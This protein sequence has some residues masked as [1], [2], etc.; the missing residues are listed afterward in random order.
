MLRSLVGSEMCIRDS[1]LNGGKGNDELYAQDGDD[2]L[3]G[4]PGANFFDCGSG[5]DTVVDFDPSKGD[6]TNDNCE[7][8]RTVL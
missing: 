5:F 2:T 7:D 1:Y 8:V 3:E 6:V 4:G